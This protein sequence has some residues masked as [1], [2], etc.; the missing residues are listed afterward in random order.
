[1]SI[2]SHKPTFYAGFAEGLIA[3]EREPLHDRMVTV[4]AW[5]TRAYLDDQGNMIPIDQRIHWKPMQESWYYLDDIEKVIADD[6]S[7]H[8]GLY[9]GI[10]G[11]FN[12]DA[13]IA[14]KSSAVL[15]VD[16]NPAQTMMWREFIKKLAQHEKLEDFIMDMA[17]ITPPENAEPGFLRSLDE[18]TQYRYQ[19]DLAN[20][21]VHCEKKFQ[22]A[23]GHFAEFLE[24][25]QDHYRNIRDDMWP[26]VFRG[27]SRGELVNWFLSGFK[28]LDTNSWCND[29]DKYR[30][31]HL[32]AKSGAMGALTL[33]IAD[34]IAC[35][36]LNQY[37]E[38]VHYQPMQEV[39]G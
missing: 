1:M 6:P 22:E 9:G 35:E 5:Q 4:P 3:L 29:E 14:A 32:L 11:R 34:P 26:S 31:L 20:F 33:D 28:Y 24:D 2:N 15:F 27:G 18:R 36:Q 8:G 19:D 37:L 25:A 23:G 39:D 13:I 7:C 17:G 38:S 30:H 10:A 21:A 16:I 12:L